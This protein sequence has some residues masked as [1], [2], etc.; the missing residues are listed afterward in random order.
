MSDLLPQGHPLITSTGNSTVKLVRSLRARKERER[1]GLYFAEGIRIVGEAMQSGA[2]VEALLVAPGLLTSAFAQGLVATAQ[3]AGT[4]VLGLSDDVF[5]HLS[6]R[7]GPQGI[8]ALVRHATGSLVGIQPGPADLWVALEEVQDPGNLGAIMRTADAV[9]ARGMILIGPAVD[10]YDPA[11]VRAS[12]GSLF[13]QLIV[14]TPGVDDLLAWR[15]RHG[16]R[17][18]G[19]SGAGA[20][21]Y[22]EADYRR[23]MILVS[24]SERQGLSASLLAACDDVVR[25]PMVGRADSL[26]LAVATS[27]VLYEALAQSS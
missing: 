3:A 27:I 25:I 11:A 20:R 24:G 6:G 21:H 9:G 18:I 17:L 14:R 12:M 7:D 4:R 5:R 13:G 2:P 26:N 16:I 19:T 15:Q 10:P 22:R 23:P 1:Q 8:G